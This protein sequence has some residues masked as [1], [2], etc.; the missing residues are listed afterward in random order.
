MIRPQLLKCIIRSSKFVKRLPAMTKKNRPRQRL[1]LQPRG[2]NKSLT[3]VK[4]MALNIPEKSEWLRRQPVTAARPTMQREKSLYRF[5][6]TAEIDLQ[7]CRL[8]FANA[9]PDGAVETFEKVIDSGGKI[10][11]M[12]IKSQRGRSANPAITGAS[13][14][15]ILPSS[16]L[17]RVHG[18]L[19]KRPAVLVPGFE[20]GTKICERK[21]N[22]A[23]S[24]P[25]AGDFHDGKQPGELLAV[26]TANIDGGMSVSLLEHPRPAGS[27][28]N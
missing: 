26:E 20:R 1:V 16:L 9:P 15:K 10:D 6:T 18:R 2:C 24:R 8:G 5:R 7:A 28:E 23:A 3:R 14:L 22:S 13:A 4:D 19:I 25:P 21:R 12:A 27:M 17:A 11:Y